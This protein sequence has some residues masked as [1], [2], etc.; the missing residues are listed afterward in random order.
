M[1]NQAW[2]QSEETP[3][4]L[5]S[6]SQNTYVEADDQLSNEIRGSNISR[7]INNR[8]QDISSRGS[9]G[10]LRTQ[11]PKANVRGKSSSVQLVATILTDVT[12][13]MAG[14]LYSS[15]KEPPNGGR[16]TFKL[17]DVTAAVPPL[18]QGTPLAAR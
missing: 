12:S 1:S 8:V 13:A 7:N 2:N 10:T 18:D 11:K 5:L 14:A 9:T 4:P 15:C 3:A 6:S 17:I 16:L